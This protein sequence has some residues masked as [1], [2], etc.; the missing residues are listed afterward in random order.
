MAAS[1]S[2]TKV[3]QGVKLRTRLRKELTSLKRKHGMGPCW[4]CR[5]VLGM[6]AG[7]ESYRIR[8]SRCERVGR[9]TKDAIKGIQLSVLLGDRP[10]G[11]LSML[12]PE[13][14]LGLLEL[15]RED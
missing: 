14:G 9:W 12:P 11:L 6:K 4:I 10:F 5:S 7:R 13:C 2:C 1:A 3:A 15:T 8:C